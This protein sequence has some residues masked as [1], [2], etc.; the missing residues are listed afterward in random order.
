MIIIGDKF[1]HFYN[2]AFKSLLTKY[3]EKHIVST[4]Y[5][6][7][8]SGQIEVSN[9]EVKRILKIMISIARKD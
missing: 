7:Q 1:S 6:S 2:K 3:G 9:R 5:H 8:T 4:H